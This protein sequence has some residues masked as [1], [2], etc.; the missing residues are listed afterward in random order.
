MASRSLVLKDALSQTLSAALLSLG[1]EAGLIS[2][3]DS[4]DGQLYLLTERGL[5]SLLSQRLRQHGMTGTPCTYAHEQ[6]ESLIS[7]DYDQEAPATI[8]EMLAE[9]AAVGLR[10]CACIPLLHKDQSLG[11]LGLFAH[12][13]RTFS[14]NEKVLLNTIGHQIATAAA[15]ARLFQTIADE[16]SR[17]QTVIESSRDGII[18]IG[19]AQRVLLANARALELLQLPGQ[20]EDWTNRPMW[21]ALLALR[22]HAPE[23][24]RATLAEV[25]RLQRGDEPPAEGEHKV[26]PRTVRW[27]SLPVLVDTT[28]LGRLLVLRDVTEERLLAKM[29]DDLIHTMVHDLRNPLTSIT[30]ALQLMDQTQE[31][32]LLPNQRMM[33]QVALDGSQRILK[34]VND[35]LDVSRLEGGRMPLTSKLVSL[36]DLVTETLRRQTLL[37]AQKNLHLENDVPSTLPPVWVDAPLIERVLENLLGNAIRFTPANGLVTVS[38]RMADEAQKDQATGRPEI[39]VS[40]SDNG[41]GI[42]PELKGRLFQ[43]FV[44]GRR[45]ESGSG[46]GLVFCKLAVEAHGGRIWVESELDQGTTV[47]FTLPMA[48]EQHDI[49]PGEQGNSP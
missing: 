14:P 34:M 36:A 44:T 42:P 46:L 31:D 6:R 20:P 17:L 24:V 37:A 32:N 5:P 29:R 10:A 1:F 21:D 48:Q 18:F 49:E 2:L 39:H 28:P 33:L 11:V 35:I 47:T 40:V 43:K 41:P 15:N 45:H 4:P 26:P 25:R 30:L 12:Q 27:L 23:M 3:A 19:M 13:A 9:M 7:S 16:R 38:A 8:K 22:H